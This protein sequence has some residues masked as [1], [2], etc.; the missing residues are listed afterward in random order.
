MK[1]DIS[2]VAAARPPLN[3]SA[4]FYANR[5]KRVFDVTFA[6]ALLP[7]LAP[8]IALLWLM[9]RCD[10]G[11]GFFHQ[12]R[13]GRDGRSFRCWK[14]RSM[15]PDAAQDLARICRSDPARAHEWQLYQ[16]LHDDP[17]VTVV[18]RFLRATSLD[19]LPQIWNVLLGDMSFV[20]P[21][22]FL[23]EQQDLYDLSGGRAYYRVR[24]GI[25]GPWQVGARNSGGFAERAELDRDYV[26]TL[27]FRGDMRVLISTVGV[28]FS[29]TGR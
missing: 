10:G 15:I 21:R 6:L 2:L 12:P 26:R 13:I 16:K 25:T 4:G 5:A 18:G 11:T 20:G 22:P 27:S 19:E 3:W 23:P 29:L 8:I 24:P 17:R 9:V 14:L 1:H 7:F 28:V